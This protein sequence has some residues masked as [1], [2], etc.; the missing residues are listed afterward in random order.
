MTENYFD[1][2]KKDISEIRI[3]K[4]DNGTNCFIFDE[5]NTHKIYAGF[6]LC[7]GKLVQTLCTVSFYPSSETGKFIPRLEFRKFLKKKESDRN[8]SKEAVRISFASKEEGYIE[9]WKMI[10]FLFKFKDLVDLGGFDET[11]KVMESNDYILTFKTKDQ[12]SKLSELSELITTSNLDE[13]SIKEVLTDSR[14]LVLEE[15]KKLLNDSDYYKSYEENYKAE[16]VGQGEEAVYHYFLKKHDWLLGLNIDVRFIR[17]FIS[18]AKTGIE[19]TKGQGSPKSDFLGFSDYTVLVELKTPNTKIF[20]TNKK[21]TSRTNTWS[22]TDDFIDGISQC[23][24]Q[25]TDWEKIHKQKNL[26]DGNDKAVN[27]DLIRTVDPKVIFIIGNKQ[28]ELPSDSAE[29]KIHVMRDTFERFRRNNR[30]LDIITYDELYERAY[31]V[32]FNKRPD[33]DLLK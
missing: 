23:L 33:F 3:G 6:I 18:E 32:V 15:F 16:I 28:K 25:K 7:D 29:T 10:S 20:S 19:D 30:N 5:N 26:I 14:K 9:F 2:T 8:T 22:F 21:S 11:F 27:Q 1:L 17:E 13:Q 12:A 4:L 31:F 24:G